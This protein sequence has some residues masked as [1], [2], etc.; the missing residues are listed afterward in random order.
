MHQPLTLAHVPITG[1]ILDTQSIRR[2]WRKD[3]DMDIVDQVIDAQTDDSLKERTN[4]AS[5]KHAFASDDIDFL[6]GSHGEIS[7]HSRNYLPRR[8]TT[9]HDKTENSKDAIM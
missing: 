4:E 6:S 8:T 2:V 7:Y 1:C 3:E 5:R 9:H